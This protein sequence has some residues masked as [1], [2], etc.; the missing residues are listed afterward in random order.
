MVK[1]MNEILMGCLNIIIRSVSSFVVLFLLS[2]LIGPRQIS[3]LTFY[4]YIVGIT[5]GSIAAEF[6]VD[7]TIPFYYTIIAMV[8]YALLTV[9]GAFMTS[10]S[11]VMRKFMTGIPSIIIDNGVIIERNL[12]KNHL[13]VNDLLSFARTQ[14][15]FNLSDIAFAIMEPTGKVSFLPR[16]DKKPLTPQD[17]KFTPEQEQLFANVVID[18]KIMHQ[19]LKTI[20]KTERWLK[21]VLKEQGYKNAKNILLASADKNGQILVYKKNVPPPD[22][23]FF[24]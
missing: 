14:G 20:Q 24:M 3:Q 23:D 4:D 19:N 13:D 6:A 1:I 5:I 16:T 12:K 11:I 7:D 22:E 21:G 15:Y 17:V 8:I 10:K 9:L 2:K 18:G